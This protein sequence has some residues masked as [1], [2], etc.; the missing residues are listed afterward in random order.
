MN[1]R[2]FRTLGKADEFPDGDVRPFYLSEC[3]LRFNVARVD[4]MLYAFNGLCAHEHCPLSAGLLEGATIMCQCHGSKYDLRSGAVL[5][6]PTREAL[7]VFEVREQQG[8]IQVK[9]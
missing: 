7:A 1:D 3:K 4:N 9:L 6:G 8:E 5:R 2:G